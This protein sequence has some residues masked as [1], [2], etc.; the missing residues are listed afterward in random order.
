MAVVKGSWLSQVLSHEILRGASTAFFI[1]IIAAGTAFVMNIVVAR[2]L[3]ATEAGLFFLSLTIVSI[4]AAAT[5]LGLD[6]SIIRFIS[7][8]QANE[9]YSA[10]KGVYR[11][12]RSWVLSASLIV[13]CVVLLMLHVYYGEIPQHPGFIKVFSLM[14]LVVPITALY[15]IN[16]QA[17]QGLRRVARA[18]LT[19]NVIMP[20]ALL[21][22]IV[23]FSV[24]SARGAAWAYIG[25]SILALLISVRWWNSCSPQAK[26]LVDYDSRILFS[27]CFPL[28]A[29]MIFGQAV[30]WSSQ[31]FIGVWGS[32]S[33]VALF[34]AAQRT[35]MLVSFTL[36]AVNSISAPKFSAMYRREDLEGLKRT[37][38]FSGRLVFI[39]SVPILIVMIL[40]PEALMG[41]FGEEFVPAAHILVILAIGQFVNVATGSVGIL[42]SMTGNEKKLR[43]NTFISATLAVGLG[44]VLI[45]RYGMVG[46]AI[47]TT[48]AVSVQHLL[49]SY[50]VNQL[51]GF[52]ALAY[53][54]R[55]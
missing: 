22:L 24:D 30:Q 17:L 5:R 15:V 33:D 8:E 1:K 27:S 14:L 54:R 4:L 41:L 31:L 53:W 11:K 52:N 13:T 3:G 26:E 25:A 2:M 35:A 23:F 28:W 49:G 32:A 43:L 44:L 51:L 48:I 29:V 19:L 55:S 36:I 7:S 6:N 46:G 20:A 42:L 39:A 16:A 40:F 18:M 45:P 21:T 10:I 34:S 37:A 12:A 47:S 50:Q 9:N 38:L